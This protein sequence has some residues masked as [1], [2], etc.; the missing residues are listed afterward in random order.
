MRVRQHFTLLSEIGFLEGSKVE[1]EVKCGDDTAEKFVS[2]DA[3]KAIA[4]TTQ[5]LE[6]VEEQLS[7]S[8]MIGLT[9]ETLKMRNQTSQGGVC[10][11][12][13]RREREG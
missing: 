9:N 11:G 12:A 7:K 13:P 8:G 5:L 2:D 1:N 6:N 3:K 10:T 4:E